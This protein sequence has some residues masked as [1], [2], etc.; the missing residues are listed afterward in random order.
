MGKIEDWR[1]RGQQ[2]M[3]CLDG[4]IESMDTHLSKLWELL[5]DREAWC[6][7]VCGV[8]KSQTQWETEPKIMASSPIILWQIEGGKV[9][10]VIDFLFLS[11]KIIVDS[12][13]SHEIKRHLLFGRKAMTKLDS[14]LKSRDIPLLPK[15]H[16]VKAVVSPVVLWELDH[17]EGWTLKNWCFQIVVLE[18]T[19]ESPL[20][21]R[22]IKPVKPKG[23]RPWIFIEGLMLKLN[24][25]YFGHLLQ[26]ANSLE[27][28]WC[29]VRLKTKGEEG[30]KGWD[31]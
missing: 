9:E 27:R 30:S 6:A 22:K 18:K 17:K 12:D 8:T 19:L 4:I 5:M 16:I 24:L 1:R 21:C 15:V 7:A 28:S 2:R 26:R 25:Q 29:W 10:A 13:C 23:N 3:R 14:V 31:G 11:T 20:D